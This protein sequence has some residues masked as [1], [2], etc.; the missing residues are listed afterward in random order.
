MYTYAQPLLRL[1]ARPMNQDERDERHAQIQA[2]AF[3]LLKEQG[4]RKTSMLAIAKRAQASN[5]TLYAWYSN[6]Q[7]LFR[8]II[9][10]FGGAVREQLLAALHDGQVPLEALQALGNLPPFDEEEIARRAKRAFAL[11]FRLYCARAAH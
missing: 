4:Y 10:G 2:A 6:K 7:A 1:D 3:A 8:G 5:Q 11:T 9:E